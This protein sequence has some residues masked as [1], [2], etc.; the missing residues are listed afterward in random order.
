MKQ[1]TYSDIKPE[2]NF[3]I[4]NVENGKCTVLFFDN[5]QEEKESQEVE[6]ENTSNKIIYSYD[7]YSIEIPYRENL[8]ETIEKDI[9]NWLNSVKEKDYNE[10]ATKVREI[11]NQLLAETDKEMCFD[12]LGIEIP[13]K[14]TA[15]NLVSVVTSVFEG[16]AK[17]LN[18]NVTKYRQELRDLPDQEGFPYNVVWPT[19]DK[20]E[21]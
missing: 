6:N 21:E 17:I 16:I 3:S 8:A 9:N 7:T 18:N 15:T 14:I 1:R 2:K 13:E 20:E 4:E 10:V 5:I 11:R 19:K 12:R